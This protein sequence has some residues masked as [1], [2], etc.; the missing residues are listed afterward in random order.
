MQKKKTKSLDW[1][2]KVQ[3]V[4]TEGERLLRGYQSI[5]KGEESNTVLSVM[6]NSY[7]PRTNK[8]FIDIVNELTVV[9]KTNAPEFSEYDSG[10]KVLAY[11]SNPRKKSIG[12]HQ[13]SDQILIGN[14]FD[15]STSL[16]VATVI[17]YKGSNFTYM[18]KKAAFRVSHR[19]K[20]LEHL[21]DYVEMMND[22][23]EE[24]EMLYNRFEEM[25][26]SKISKDVVDDFIKAV[27]QYKTHDDEGEPVEI[28]TR[29][30]NKIDTM[31]ESIQKKFNELGENVWALFNGVTDYTTYH[32]TGSK[33]QNVDGNMYGTQ[34]TY[35]QRALNYCLD[36][37]A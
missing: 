19:T 24:K 11:L 29:T 12:G 25:S 16:F 14:S 18:N 2:I 20:E 34:N 13:I 33:K 35:N 17:N 6:K 7:N 32:Y 23:E 10:R 27:I 4:Y 8:E 9:A 31:K 5:I 36:L 28:S 30:Q 22:Y 1:E 21:F 15:G 26:D 37:L 3:P